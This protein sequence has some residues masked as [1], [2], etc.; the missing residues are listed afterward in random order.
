V[1]ADHH[2]LEG[3]TLAEWGLKWVW[4]HPEVSV[5][6]VNMSHSSQVEEYIAYAAGIEPDS[7]SIQEKVLISRVRETYKM[8][9]PIPCTA[10]RA[11]MPCPLG[12]DVPRIFEIYNDAV[13]YDDAWRA[14]IISQMERHDIN[15]CTACESCVDACAKGLD[16]IDFLNKVKI[17]LSGNHG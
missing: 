17:F 12:I 15:A 11:C 6:I 5:A 16:L 7:L 14:R 10:C 1:W 8:S 4:D 9:R 13:I 3:R 2:G